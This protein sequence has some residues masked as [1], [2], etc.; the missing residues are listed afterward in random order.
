MRIMRPDEFWAALVGAVKR[1]PRE[2]RWL[3]AVLVTLF[4]VSIAIVVL[5]LRSAPANT[6]KL[7]FAKALLQLGVVAVAGAIVSFLIAEYQRGRQKLDKERELSR[8][9]FEYR[10]D[11]LKSILIRAM[12]AYTAV[13]KA[14]RLLRA[15]A[16]RGDNPEVVLKDS[17]DLYLGMIN[18]AQLALENLARDISNSS[19]A[20][21]DSVTL[22]QKVWKMEHYLSELVEEYEER[23]RMF[24]DDFPFANLPQLQEFVGHGGRNFRDELQTPFHDVQ[25]AIR[26]DLIHPNLPSRNTPP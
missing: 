1:L 17:Y 4:L 20:F 15:R 11:L 21:T 25:Q 14:R 6:V 7:E 16:I 2:L 8:N 5:F 24:Q 12:D 13:K 10:E 9:R 18:D 19:P 23:R 26:E 22:A 3:I